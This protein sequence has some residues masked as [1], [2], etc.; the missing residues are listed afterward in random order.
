M[1]RGARG[2]TAG[3]RFWEAPT[4]DAGVGAAAGAAIRKVRSDNMGHTP[5]RREAQ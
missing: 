2:G 5:G 3:S 4:I 1:E